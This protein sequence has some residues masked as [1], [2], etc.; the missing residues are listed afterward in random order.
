MKSAPA[1]IEW[2]KTGG[3][4]GGDGGN[5]NAAT[6]QS[7]DGS[8]DKQMVD[9]NGADFDLQF[10]GAELAEE[11]LLYGLAGFRAKTFDT[12]VGVVAGKRGQVH[13]GDRA[14][15]PGNLPV[16]FHC[17]ARDQGGGTALDGGGINANGFDPIEIE[18]G[19]SVGM[20]GMT[21]KGC[22][23]ALAGK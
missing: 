7:F 11:F 10:A 23:G 21:G 13:A 6:L 12:F 16:F 17:A 8:F 3:K 22:D 1:I 20:K 9:A 18:G 2:R 15:E 5:G 14:Q 19:A 4:A